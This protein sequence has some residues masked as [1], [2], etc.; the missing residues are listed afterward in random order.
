MV[1][2]RKLCSCYQCKKYTCVDHD[3]NNKEGQMLISSTWSRHKMKHQQWL[4]KQH[5]KNKKNTQ[6]KILTSTIASDK[7]NNHSIPVWQQDHGTEN[8]SA[9]ITETGLIGTKSQADLLESGVF[10]LLLT[11]HIFFLDLFS[12]PE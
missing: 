10:S 11:M 8:P 12:V 3:G 7:P 2:D 5:A 9:I 4:S 1:Q 6:V